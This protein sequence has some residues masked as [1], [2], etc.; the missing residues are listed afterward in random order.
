MTERAIRVVVVEDQLLVRRGL[1]ELLELEESVE[2]VGEARDGVEALPEIARLEPDVVLV[3]AR[4][5]RMDGVELIERLAERYPDTATI[6]LSTFDDDAYVFGGLRAG[7]RGYLLKDTSP[8]DLVDA[9]RKAHAGELVLGGPI[10]ARLVA[11]VTKQP[12]PETAT[13]GTG[14][15]T[16]TPREIEVAALVGR[17]ATNAEIADALYITEGTARNQVSRILAKL[18]LRDRIQLALY[19]ATRWPEG[20]R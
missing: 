12:P 7:A 17:G 5:P 4:M 18:G 9:I 3:D 11:E 1:V 14:E 20:R 6:I 15:E 19:A 8:E 13:E 2:V 16:L 10:T